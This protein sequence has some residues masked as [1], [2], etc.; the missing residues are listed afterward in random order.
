ML[1]TPQL[2]IQI[3][4]MF[5]AFLTCTC[6]TPLWKRFHHPWSPYNNQD[7]NKYC[8]FEVKKQNH[9]SVVESK[10]YSVADT[11]AW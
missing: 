8:A 1:V 3:T 5:Y 9:A 10:V 4:K 2:P 11:A 7:R 6:A